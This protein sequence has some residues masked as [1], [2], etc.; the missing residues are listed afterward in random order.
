MQLS[1]FSYF[2]YLIILVSR[3]NGFIYFQG[4][5]KQDIA[6]AILF[7]ITSYSFT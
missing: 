1:Q 5:G 4:I 6:V 2:Q 7:L 3:R